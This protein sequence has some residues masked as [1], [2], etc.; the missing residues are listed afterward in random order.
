VT[1]QVKYL[2][3]HFRAGSLLVLRVDSAG[4]EIV[5]QRTNAGGE[6]ESIASNF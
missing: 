2:S 6:H 3:R 1:E 5:R 4:D